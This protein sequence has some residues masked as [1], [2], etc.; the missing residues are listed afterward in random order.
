M[1]LVKDA[2][3]QVKIIPENLRIAQPHQKTYADCRRR[4]LHFK[5]GNCHTRFI[6]T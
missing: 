3:N 4:D 5:M 1:D 6:R 2:E